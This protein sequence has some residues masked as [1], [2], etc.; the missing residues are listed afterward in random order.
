M[1]SENR[2]PSHLVE[3][4]EELDR[5]PYAFDFFQAIR[6]LDCA[7]PDTP[8][9]GHSA[10]L[11]DDPFRLAQEP[12][13]AFAP[14]T[15]SEMERANDFHPP[16]LIQRFFGLLGP[17]GPLPVHLTD[18]AR[19]RIRHHEDHTFMRFLDIFHHRM[20]GLFYRSWARVRPTVNFD[21]GSRDRFGEYV[22]SVFGLGMDSLENRDAMP[23]TP[24][25]HFAGLLGGQTK[26]ADGLLAIIRGYFSL[27]TEME[28]FVGQWIELP[29]DC[30]CQMG[31][32]ASNSK[33]G[34][35][36]T[37]GSHV[38]DCQQKFRLV[39]GPLDLVEYYHLLPANAEATAAEEVSETTTT[40][41][42]HRQ[43]ANSNS[44]TEDPQM[45]REQPN[46]AKGD[47]QLLVTDSDGDQVALRCLTIEVDPSA[48]P[49]TVSAKR[50]EARAVYQRVSDGMTF[51]D[52]VRTYAADAAERQNGGRL[53]QNAFEELSQHVRANVEILRPGD[54]TVPLRTARGFQVFCCEHTDGTS[55]AP[56][57][58]SPRQDDIAVSKLVADNALSDTENNRDAANPQKKASEEKTATASGR[59]SL[60]SLIALVRGYVGD[61]LEWDLQLTLKKEEA[62]PLGLGIQGHLGW[63]TWLLRDEIQSNPEDLILDVVA[64]CGRDEVTKL[65]YQMIPKWDHQTLGQLR[66]GQPVLSAQSGDSLD[67]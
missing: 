21:D 34:Q 27:P 33:L 10:A 38:W 13:M 51:V 22:T 55:V 30:Q 60:D 53:T 61:D 63:T 2:A 39:M 6:L 5:E 40:S 45:S 29:S 26:H 66:D 62:P 24:K 65:Q 50:E 31:S 42:T 46:E 15:L 8:Q 58:I 14:A 20:L 52:A 54:I 43:H 37:I 9:T 28:Q 3:L 4:L 18:Y 17:Q 25:R 67:S 12:S 1:A 7:R 56:P 16:R 19:T 47:D 44:V 49:E 57:Q 59:V 36:I 23:D 11:K 64:A 32:S 35:T 41:A 48:S